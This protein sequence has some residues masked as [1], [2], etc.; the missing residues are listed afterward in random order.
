MLAGHT[1]AFDFTDEVTGG[2]TVLTVPQEAVIV[3]VIGYHQTV[4]SFHWKITHRSLKDSLALM[5][6]WEE[7]LA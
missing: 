2:I 4:L 6:D 1:C 3:V 7:L 5:L